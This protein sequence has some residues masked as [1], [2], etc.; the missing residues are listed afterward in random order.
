MASVGSGSTLTTIQQAMD[1][2][3]PAMAQAR[4][5]QQQLQQQLYLRQAQQSQ[6]GP[7]VGGRHNPLWAGEVQLGERQSGGSS[8]GGSSS[9]QNSHGAH[10]LLRQPSQSHASATSPAGAAVGLTMAVPQAP[11]QKLLANHRLPHPVAAGGI[12]TTPH[13]QLAIT[14]PSA[15]NVN[16]PSPNSAVVQSQ[17][18]GAALLHTPSASGQ[19]TMTIDIPHMVATVP[20]GLHI[21]G[22]PNQG[23]TPVLAPGAFPTTTV[24][25]PTGSL[26]GPSVVNLQLAGYHPVTTGTTQYVA[27]PQQTFIATPN[28]PFTI[29]TATNAVAGSGNPL[30]TDSVQQSGGHHSRTTDRGEDS[31][32]VGVCVQPSPVASH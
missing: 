19:Q 18:Q 17:P 23:P 6:L 7:D 10:Q 8:S 28:F 2:E 4:L 25:F 3:S 31:P 9:G 5:Q 16:L 27:V 29:A 20:T 15:V 26:D 14:N 21:Q 22:Q 30:T 32:M 13:G 24:A 11:T 1:C 12:I